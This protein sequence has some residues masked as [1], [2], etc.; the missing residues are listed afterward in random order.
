MKFKFNSMAIIK[1]IKS[2]DLNSILTGLTLK[3]KIKNYKAIQCKEKLLDVFYR[4]D[5]ANSYKT[6][7]YRENLFKHIT[8]RMRRK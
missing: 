5:V 7:I 8:P 1:L 2:I 3:I 4:V 6:S